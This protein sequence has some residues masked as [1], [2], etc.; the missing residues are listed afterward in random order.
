MI[1]FLRPRT[2]VAVL[3][4]LILSVAVYGFAAANV[5]PG[6]SA[7]DGSGA[8]SGYTI[9]GIHYALSGA[10]PGNIATVTFTIAPAAASD[11][12]ITMDGA[13]WSTC[14]NTAGAVSCAVNQPALTALNLRVVA[15][16]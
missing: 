9:T 13:T 6:S 7:G 10:N 2:L 12:R 11:V 14:T 8:I 3:L 15:A 5:V 1:R 16:E 4:V